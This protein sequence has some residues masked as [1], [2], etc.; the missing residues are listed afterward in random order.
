MEQI[1]GDDDNDASILTLIV[2]TNPLAWKLRHQFG[3]EN[4]IDINDLIAQL[5]IFCHSYALMHRSN[6]IVVIANHPAESVILYPRRKGYRSEGSSG[7]DATRDDFVPFAHT[8]Q[9]VMAKGLLDCV[10]NDAEV[11]GQGSACAQNRVHTEE[12]SS[13]AQALSISLCGM[14]ASLCRLLFS[15]LFFLCI[16]LP[17]IVATKD[18]IFHINC[19]SSS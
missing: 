1:R 9:T 11:R 2:D 10:R 5:I 16:S 13:L 4:M 7:I 8:L 15:L 14:V 12:T 18:L 19:L 17:T 3:T 6:R